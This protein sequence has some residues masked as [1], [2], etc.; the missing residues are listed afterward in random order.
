V[1]N[2]A[3]GHDA[4][5]VAAK[6]LQTQ[7]Y[8]ILAINWRHTRAEIDIIAQKD[9]GPVLLVEVKYRESATQATALTIL[10]LVK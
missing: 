3:H 1:T 9:S 2:Y 4:E 6:Y 10:R 8:T 7:G 5:K